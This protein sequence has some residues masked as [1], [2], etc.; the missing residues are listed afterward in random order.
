MDELS[1]FLREWEENL[2]PR[3]PESADPPARILGYGEIS[4]VLEIDHPTFRG[5]TVKR[6][7]M[8]RDEAEVRDYVALH[9]D[10]LDLLTQ[11]GIELP[12]TMPAWVERPQGGYAVYMLQKKLD[13]A[14]IG[15][16][17]LHRVSMED[18][19]RLV[20][21][22]VE[23]MRKVFRFNQ[24][25]EGK[26]ALGFDGQISNWSVQNLPPDADRLPE[27]VHLLYFDTTTPLIRRNGQ[28]QINTE[29]FL[30]SAPS[31][32]VWIIRLLFLEDVVTR[33]YDFR[34]VVVDLIA[35]LYKEKRAEWIPA[36]V[37]AANAWKREMPELRGEDFTEKEIRSYYRE[38]AFIW[39]FYL[40]ARKIDRSLHGL[41]GKEYPYILPEKIER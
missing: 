26:L 15:N 33:Y 16:K 13:P 10:Y 29:L 24:E 17:V 6:M 36:L 19:I 38:D 37:D 11:A 21:A 18:G 5:Y 40:A 32:L 22:T 2:D 4:T 23:E 25:H 9:Q 12:E 39:R 28:E 27:N 3:H 14:S 41:L 1:S 31:F 30:R 20:R 7:P 35:N 34:L 8:F